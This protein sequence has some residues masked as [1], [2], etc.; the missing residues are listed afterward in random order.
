MKT[1]KIGVIGGG[2]FG[3][4]AS[5]ILGKNHQ[6]ELFERNS[7]ILKSASGSGKSNGCSHFGAAS[8][9]VNSL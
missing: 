4:T 8:T 1:K 2:I 9:T 7:D 6:V 5:I 3:I